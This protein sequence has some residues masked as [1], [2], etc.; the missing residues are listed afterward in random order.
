MTTPCPECNR[1]RLKV[2]EASDATART[3]ALWKET[4]AP[5][6]DGILVLLT[7]NEHVQSIA[8]DEYIKHIGEVHG[9]HPLKAAQS[10]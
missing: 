3:A 6:S 7:L 2:G 10:R 1:L 8:T 9:R 4:P 5:E